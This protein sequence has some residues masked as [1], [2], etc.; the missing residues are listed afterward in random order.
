MRESGH[1]QCRGVIPTSNKAQHHLTTSSPL[2]TSEA[3]I[4]RA[5]GLTI[6]RALIPSPGRVPRWAA[7]LTFGG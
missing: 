2:L 4:L 1:L 6:S 5:E 7:R 3:E